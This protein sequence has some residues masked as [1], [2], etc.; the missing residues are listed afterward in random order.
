METVKIKMLKSENGSPD[1]ITVLRYMA[2]QIYDVPESLAEIF[3]ETMGV[4]QPVS[5]RTVDD[6]GE[7]IDPPKQDPPKEVTDRPGILDT[8]ARAM[9]EELQANPE[10]KEGLF[11]DKGYPRI[12]V[13]RERA[14]FEVTSMER[15]QIWEAISDEIDQSEEKISIWNKLFV[16]KDK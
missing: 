12:E 15:N 11:T 13:M 8:H 7:K 14:G 4:A 10:L 9:Y 16:G 5:V 6:Q 3:I 2:D 1:G